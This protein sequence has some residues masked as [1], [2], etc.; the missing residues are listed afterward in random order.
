MVIYLGNA[1]EL[2]ARDAIFDSPA[3]SLYPGASVRDAGRRPGREARTHPAYRRAAV[4][5]RAAAGL[6]VPPALPARLRS[7]P[8][9][10][11]AARTEAGAGRRLLGGGGMSADD[12]RLHHCRRGLR[13]LRARQSAE[14]RSP[15]PRARRRGRR[16]GQLDLVPYSGRL[17]LRD[18]QSARRLDVQDGAR[19]EPRRPLDRLSARP[20]GGRMLGHQRDDLH[21][22]AG[23]RLRRLAPARP[24]RLGLGR[25]SALFSPPGGPSW[26]R[27]RAARSGRRMAGRAS[28]R[29][30]AD[31]R[32]RARRGRRDRHSED[33]RLQS[34]R[35]R[36]LGLFRGQPAPRPALE[37]G[38]GVPEAD[39]QA[40]ESAPRDRRA[41]RAHPV[42]GPP[43]RG[44]ALHASTAPAARRGRRAK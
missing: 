7:L 10:E 25:R 18:R 44:P 38:D 28:A 43:R 3:A 34:R 20:G 17:S 8:D 9:R 35:Q 12:L 41:C 6:P 32:R 30:L 29:L 15:Q 19:A 22:R 36:G 1:V 11:A 42:R 21:A 24:C 5:D 37:R 4:A 14:P 31:P 2:G 33:R 39:P 13:R 40:A 27:E 23:G 16:P 26:R